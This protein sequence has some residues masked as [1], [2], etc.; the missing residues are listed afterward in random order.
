M[1]GAEDSKVTETCSDKARLPKA[2][3][4]RVRILN[5]I[6]RTRNYPKVESGDS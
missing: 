1:N 2:S 4:T 5:L 6:M 3:E